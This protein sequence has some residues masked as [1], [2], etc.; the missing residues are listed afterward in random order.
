MHSVWCFICCW[1]II[2]IPLPG[3]VAFF[4]CPATHPT[5][6]FSAPCLLSC[7]STTAAMDST[8]RGFRDL[9]APSSSATIAE[10]D[11][12]F[13]KSFPSYRLPINQLT[14]ASSEQSRQLLP[15]LQTERPCTSYPAGEIPPALR[16][17]NPDP[18]IDSSTA[19]TRQNL[20]LHRPDMGAGVL[21]RPSTNEA[22]R[23]LLRYPEAP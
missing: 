19:P 1:E 21:H 10:I 13:G 3:A 8:P 23:S 17:Q 20:Y 15:E 11:G 12:V 5:T 7:T 9:K 2:Y 4:V 18:S 6:V 14:T 22:R 16:Q